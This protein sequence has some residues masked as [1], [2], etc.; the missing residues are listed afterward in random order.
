MPF[1][2]NMTLLI[3]KIESRLGVD[4]LQLPDNIKK[5]TWPEK[6]VIP[7]TL[8]T[9]SRFF[10]NEFKYHID[11]THKMK[12]GWYILDEELFQDCKILGIKNLDWGD[13]NSNT[14]GSPYG[15]YDYMAAS[16]DIGDMFG[17]VNQA[18]INS[19]FNNG[20]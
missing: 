14:F 17:L 16:Y 20:L 11:E 7:D 15:I 2:N 18:N 1:A 9:W 8:T 6:V 3:N 4:Q 12:N 5:E 19:L 10:P 13:F